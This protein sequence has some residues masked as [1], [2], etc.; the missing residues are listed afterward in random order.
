M[1]EVF[2]S[3]V[4]FILAHGTML[5]ASHN[6]KEVDER[7]AWAPLVMTNVSK[8]IFDGIFCKTGVDVE[9]GCKIKKNGHMCMMAVAGTTGH[10]DKY[11]AE[12]NSIY[13]TAD[14]ILDKSDKLS[15][16]PEA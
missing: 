10:M 13:K 11:K 4:V 6:S 16:C 5:V 2:V 12:A 3:M 8:Q 15:K 7:I 14:K 9:W 1:P